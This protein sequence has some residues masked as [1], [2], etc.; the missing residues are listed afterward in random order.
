M[1]MKVLVPVISGKEKSEGFVSRVLSEG[2]EIV[3]L[4]IVDEEF[5]TKAGSAIGEVRNFRMAVE[6]IK[7]SAIA[8][9]KKYI[10]LTEWGATITKIISIAILHGVDKVFLVKQENQF[11]EDI[12]DELKKNKIKFE[13][14]D[15]VGEVVE[16]RSV[17]DFFGRKK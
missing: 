9:K 12:I 10:E 3:L 4:Q 5:H 7:K 13:V 1:F 17:G 16:K 2:K 14:V 6:E 11:F 8:R 15:V